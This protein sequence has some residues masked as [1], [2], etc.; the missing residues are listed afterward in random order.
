[1]ALYEESSQVESVMTERYDHD[2]VAPGDRLQ[3]TLIQDKCDISGR[4]VDLW[5]KTAGVSVVTVRK[6]VF[7]E[8][9]SRWEW[10][11]LMK[12]CDDQSFARKDS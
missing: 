3:A 10:R 1:M 4:Q 9:L 11:R 12:V 7:G 2:R 5:A 6:C 8:S